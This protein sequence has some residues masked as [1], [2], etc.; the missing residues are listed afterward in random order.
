MCFHGDHGLLIIQVATSCHFRDRSV[1]KGVCIVSKAVLSSEY[2][3]YGWEN[4]SK[5]PRVP[6]F[7][8]SLDSSIL[9]P[10]QGLGD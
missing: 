7:A 6:H 8:S 1:K 5:T 4:V 10:S 2:Q 3:G 9:L